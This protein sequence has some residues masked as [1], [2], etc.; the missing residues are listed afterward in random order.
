MNPTERKRLAVVVGTLGEAFGRQVSE[1]TIRAYEVGL[2]DL[3]I[4]AVEAAARRCIAEARYMPVPAELRAM[5]G[6][7][8][9]S[10]RAIKAW[11]A[12]TRARQCHGYY[13]SVQFDDPYTTATIRNLWHT[14]MGFDDACEQQEEHW[15]R[16]EFERVYVALLGSGIS[17]SQAAPLLGYFERENG[18]HGHTVKPAVAIACGLPPAR[19]ALPSPRPE[20]LTIAAQPAARELAIAALKAAE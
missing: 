15:L 13:D 3:P 2:G 16:R 5:C 20:R 4:D 19:A 12:V 6:E 9:P 7:L 17:E 8:S 14:W 11:E 1:V 18:L 10:Q